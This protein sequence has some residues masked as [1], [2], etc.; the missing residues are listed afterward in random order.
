MSAEQKKKNQN[1]GLRSS[2]HWLDWAMR[3]LIIVSRMWCV[4]LT[5][6][7][8]YTN[9]KVQCFF[10]YTK[11]NVVFRCG[12]YIGLDRFT[13]IWAGYNGRREWKSRHCACTAHTWPYPP[14]PMQCE[15]YWLFKLRCIYSNGTLLVLLITLRKFNIYLR[16]ID[17]DSFNDSWFGRYYKITLRSMRAF[18][19][20]G[21][22]HASL[23][24]IAFDFSATICSNEISISSFLAHM[25]ANY[26]ALR[27]FVCNS[28]ICIRMIIVFRF[29]HRFCWSACA[30]EWWETANRTKWKWN[31]NVSI[32]SSTSGNEEWRL[33]RSGQSKWNEN[34]YRKKWMEY[35][36]CFK[37][38]IREQNTTWLIFF[39]FY[40]VY[41]CST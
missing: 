31:E 32:R 28:N 24:L 9:D 21:V 38:M 6:R 29:F 4:Y 12:F 8:R 23:H 14:G 30:S 33:Q 37:C 19:T 2:R 35:F 13:W 25:S 27:Q 3:F 16:F 10:F 41:I 39:L 22:R 17:P 18:L 15:H 36:P 40:P 5:G 26:L 34:K 11:T 20:E 7:L 1:L